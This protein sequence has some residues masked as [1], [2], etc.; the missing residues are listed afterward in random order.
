MIGTKLKA[1]W[2]KVKQQCIDI[3]DKD[4]GIFFLIALVALAVKFRDILVDFLIN[5]AKR[6]DQNAQKQDS[7]LANQ[8]TDLKKQADAAVDQAAKDAPK[9]G[10]VTDD[11]YKNDN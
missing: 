7:V 3:F 11:W 2:D 1:F 10:P 6:V 5:S 8:E 4:K 9:D